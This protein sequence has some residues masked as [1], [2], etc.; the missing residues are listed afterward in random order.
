M[1]VVFIVGTVFLTRTRDGLR[2]MAVGA[3]AEAVRRA[4][5]AAGDKGV[6]VHGASIAQRMLRAGLLDEIQIHLV[7]V[8]LGEGVR[9]FE[10][11][12]AEHTEL[13]PVADRTGVE[14]DSVAIQAAFADPGAG[15]HTA[16]ID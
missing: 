11:L 1:A 7:P 9:L 3:N 13:E 4:K 8:L 16:T 5:D 2:L 10:H 15:T 6:L 14:G 12:G